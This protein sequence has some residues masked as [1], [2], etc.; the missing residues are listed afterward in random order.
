M[1]LDSIYVLHQHQCNFLNLYSI[2]DD[3]TLMHHKCDIRHVSMINTKLDSDTEQRVFVMF[4]SSGKP[5]GVN[6]YS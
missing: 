3:A 2:L 4:G 5:W 1:Y 6:S